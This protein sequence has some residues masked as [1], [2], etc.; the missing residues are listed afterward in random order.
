MEMVRLSQII[1]DC[2]KVSKKETLRRLV[3]LRSFI[4]SGIRNKVAS[5][6]YPPYKSQNELL[7]EILGGND[8]NNKE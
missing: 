7:E 1:A 2:E 3:A 5:E 4:R 6:Q 8:E